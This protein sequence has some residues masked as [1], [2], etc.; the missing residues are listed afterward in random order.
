MH[1]RKHEE[2][3]NLESF[4]N[5]FSCLLCKIFEIFPIIYTFLE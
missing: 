3:K 4:V 2:N 1:R 5:I